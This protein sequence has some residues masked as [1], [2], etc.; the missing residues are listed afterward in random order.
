MK[1]LRLLGTWM[2]ASA[3]V[4]QLSMAIAGPR[5]EPEPAA[6]KEVLVDPND[7]N[8]AKPV[9]VKNAPPPDPRKVEKGL[10]MYTDFCQKCH[11]LDMVSPGGGF[12]DL[13]TFPHDD[14][15]RFARSVAEG[16]RAMPAWGSVL[17][18][19]DIDALWAYVLTGG[20][21]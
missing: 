11:G 20:K 16:K 2:A 1:P 17:S 10:R 12:F 21:P 19:G 7:P 3:L 9:A 14:R 6:P 15:N 18:P 4:M 8:S 13:R 5:A